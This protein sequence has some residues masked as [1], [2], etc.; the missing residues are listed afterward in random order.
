M[1][2]DTH[3]EGD[4]SQHRDAKEDHGERVLPAQE[5]RV[6]VTN[7]RNHN[8]DESHGGDDPSHVAQVVDDNLAGVGV[9]PVNI[10][11]CKSMCKKGEMMISKVGHTSIV[12]DVDHGGS[13]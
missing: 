2:R 9:E 10:V 12:G 13:D 7:A 5:T 6:E 3:L 8:P 11:R 4:H 1:K